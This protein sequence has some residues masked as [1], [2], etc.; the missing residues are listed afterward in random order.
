MRLLATTGQGR[1]AVSKWKRTG[2]DYLPTADHDEYYPQ[3][4]PAEETYTVVSR[5]TDSDL[6]RDSQG[7]LVITD[8]NGRRRSK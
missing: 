6:A 8:K 1:V 4:K 7:N 2:I 3:G 5:G